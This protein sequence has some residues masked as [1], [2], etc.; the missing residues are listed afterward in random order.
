MCP[1]ALAAL[2][3]ANSGHAKPYG[4]DS[5]TALA[6]DQ[7][8]AFFSAPQAQ[9]FF[10]P[11]GT[12]SNALALA[13]LCQ[14]YHSVICHQT[15]HIET[16]ECG[17]PEFASN[18]TKL[19]TVPGAHGR[20][21]P[22][23]VERMVLRR[24][25]I[26]YPKPKVVSLTQATEVGTVYS[27]TEIIAISAVARRHGLHVHLD[28]ARFFNALA[29]LDCSAAAMTW[30]AG[31]DVV[32]LGGTKNGL[33]IGEVVVFFDPALAEDFAYRVKQAGH[34]PAKLRYVAAPW[35]ALLSIDPGG[36]GVAIR[37]ARAAN[38]MAQRLAR[39]FTDVG[40]PPCHPV[41]ANEVFI[42][43]PDILVDFLHAR[44]W[45]FYGFIGDGGWR[46]VSSWDS[47]PEDVDLLLADVR[48]GLQT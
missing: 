17:A 43:L 37:N 22:D 10:V 44:G 41:E 27:L 18:G 4:D 42:Q 39:G 23:A 36:E 19:L 11:T 15:A 2:I 20:L 25:D 26:H 28:G 14:S 21:T 30:Q 45:H 24:Q 33:G 29:H 40:L 3:A 38:A 31:V 9:M 6:A 1:E 8:R 7:V 35:T 48:A 16:D 13:S 32:C 5:W 47:T 34:L 46:F 12:A